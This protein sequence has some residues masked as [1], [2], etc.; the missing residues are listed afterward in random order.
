MTKGPG[1]KMAR[2]DET[3]RFDRMERVLY[4]AVI[5]D[6][7]DEVGL[8]NHTLN[9]LIRPLRE[10]MVLAGR[11]F[12]IIVSE[13]YEVKDEPYKMIIEA[14]DSL[15]K[16]QVPLLA[17]N[18]C[19]TT[20]MW[21]E[22]LSTASRAR[23]AR[24]TI[25]DGLSRDT[26]K[27]L[28]MRYPVFCTGMMPTDSKGRAEFIEYDCPVHSGDAVVRPGD[29]VFA[30][31]D[32]SVAIPFEAEDDVLKIAYTKATKENTV[33]RELLRGKLLRE[34]WAKHRVL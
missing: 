18:N 22:L 17:T 11:A 23:G 8:R 7:L 28:A 12:P 32:G 33:R 25:V 29:I 3:L 31:Y 4:S 30:D 13:I 21:G 16:N 9:R 5:S 10:Q 26:R 2:S 20:A 14:L 24:G 6:A 27:I 34:A 19:V 15:K 1:L